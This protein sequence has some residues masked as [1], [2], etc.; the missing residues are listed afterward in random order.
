MTTMNFKLSPTLL[1]SLTAG[2]SGNHVYAY[3]FAFSSGNLIASTSLIDNGVAGASSINLPAS[4]PSGAVYVVIQQGGNGTLPGQ[5]HAIGD[6]NPSNAQAGNYSYQL[7]EATLSSSP[8]DQ[9]DISS[10]NT[11]GMPATFEV[12]FQNGTSQTRGYAPGLTGEAIYNALGNTQTFSPNSFASAD[13]LS[14][15]PATAN[16]ATPWPAS[17]WTAYVNAFKASAATL[18][19]IQL[20][21]PFTGNTPLQATPMLSQYGVQY[22]A[23]DQYGKDYFWLVPNTMHGATNTDWIRI[24]ASQLMQNI[25]VQPGPL[26]VHVGGKDG[27]V[28]KLESFTPNNADGAVAKYF[29]AGFDA[30]YWGGSGTSPNPHDPTMID[31]NHTWSWNF[32]YAYNATLNASA[33]RYMNVLGEGPGTAGGNNRFYDPWAQ[34]IQKNSNAYGYSYTDLVSEGGVNP[35]IT[36]WDSSANANVATV[37]ISLYANS[38]VLPAGSGHVATQVPYVPP[39]G[40][41]YAPALTQAAMANQ[42]QFSFNFSLGNLKF[43]PD[44]RTPAVFKFYAPSDPTAGGDGFVSLKIPDSTDGFSGIWNYMQLG[45]SASGWTLTPTNKAGNPGFFD[46]INVPVTA[47]GSTAWYQLVFGAP[48]HQTVYNIYAKSDP[49][50]HNFLDISSGNSPNPSNFVV[51]HGVSILEVDKSNY[52]LN[53]APGGA[54]TYDIATFSAPQTIFGT[55]AND[56]V[57]GNSDDNIL[58]AGV[59][60]DIISGGAG[61]DTAV[62]WQPAKNFLI[63]AAPGTSAITLEDKVG[64]DGT[65]KLIDVEQLQFADQTLSVSWI[66][67]AANLPASEILKIVDLYVAGLDRAPDVVGLTYWASQLADGRS[68]GEIS[69]S[70]FAAPEAVAIYASTSSAASFVETAYIN[71][72]GRASDPAGKA[73]WVG[74]LESGHLARSDFITAF[75]AGAHAPTGNLA[76]ARYVA[77]KEEVGAHF[78][79]T[80]GLNNVE[81]ARIVESGID[82]STESVTAAK[83]QTEAFAATAAMPTSSELVVE[84]IGIVMEPF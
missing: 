51:D 42:I 30:G 13:R 6:I 21:V 69:K 19:D 27:P 28:Q 29:I 47:D 36:L 70:F 53:F 64:A 60:D 65:D 31:L 67:K 20:V 50:T 43:A 80:E 56:T 12:V 71:A 45:H 73:Y 46:I 81:W 33:I 35:Q 55:S 22:V 72:L 23:E 78:A 79:L 49:T 37:N 62:S 2:G 68:L 82:V 5:I 32:N 14:I 11:F 40:A 83:Q 24:P 3:A 4:F 10:L 17:D 54:M 75:I 8:F 77:N 57:S 44:D 58:N 39:S 18:N 74:E 1:Q 15:G 7:F 63:K 66:T 26:E 61:N 59:G 25:Y 84:L 48:G 76:D 16:N 52:S 34:Y 38:E 9:G 41:T